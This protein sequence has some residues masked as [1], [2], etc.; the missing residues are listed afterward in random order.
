MLDCISFTPKV[1]F[2]L[3]ELQAVT[4][5]FKKFCR[6]KK[7]S[8]K[9]STFFKNKIRPD[10]F[11]MKLAFHLLYN[12]DF[13]IVCFIYYKSV[14]LKIDILFLFQAPH[15]N[16]NSTSTT[17]STDSSNKSSSASTT[18]AAVTIE[19]K[20]D[21]EENLSCSICQE[22]MHDCIR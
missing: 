7:I 15:E 9:Y 5:K 20:D 21:I 11:I 10:I 18:T 6:W 19:K 22:I 2:E 1:N 12:S 3:K 16:K 14:V 13:S 4:G 8:V 17:T